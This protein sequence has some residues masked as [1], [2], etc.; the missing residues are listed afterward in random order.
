LDDPNIEIPD[1]FDRLS[2]KDAKK[3]IATILAQAHTS[4]ELIADY[5]L[6]P[7]PTYHKKLN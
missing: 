6:H 1:D 4:G 2:Y 5:T 3:V 7:N